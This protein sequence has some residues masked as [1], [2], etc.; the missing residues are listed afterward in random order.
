LRQSLR[1]FLL[2]AVLLSALLLLDG[3]A[4][5][6]EAESDASG[7][8]EEVIKRILELRQQIEDL[9]EMLP[10]DVRR[11]VER[12]WREG[13][14]G[15]PD[16]AVK[17]VEEAVTG[18]APETSVEP[19][20]EPILSTEPALAP[21]AA[22]ASEPAAT[23][24]PLAEQLEVVAAPPCGGFHLFDTNGDSFVSGGDR[25]WRFLRLWLDDNGNG[26][27]EEDE[28][29]SLFELGV[30]QIG[31]GLD[32]YLNDEG[33]SE[34][35]DVDEVIWLRG[36]GKGKANRRSGALAVAADRLVS[37]GRFWL[38]DRQGVQLT[39]YQPLGLGTLLDTH[40]GERLPVLCQEPD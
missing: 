40:E 37:D 3:P 1:S 19:T 26:D 17:P 27:L 4:N 5:A 14:V 21:E 30:R 15:K 16:E 29:K 33:D 24:E 35:V 12:R 10:A 9:L 25:Q 36:V 23:E 7:S 18:T 39:G 38:T 22:P 31:V 6:E 32:I 11:E 20:V 8:Q 34:D 2:T 13:H 28:V